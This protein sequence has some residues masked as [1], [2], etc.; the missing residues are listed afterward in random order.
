LYLLLQPDIPWIADG[1]RD[2]GDRR[3]EMHDLFKQKLDDMRLR[4]VDVAGD[5]DARFSNAIRA[6][7]ELDTK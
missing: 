4:Y 2:R 5:R 1:V 6:I 3:D 7:D